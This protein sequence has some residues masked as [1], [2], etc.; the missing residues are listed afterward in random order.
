MRI[1]Q[2]TNKKF[3]NYGCF[4]QESMDNQNENK[5]IKD[6][7]KFEDE[8]KLRGYSKKTISAYL[9]Y[10]KIFFD[11]KLSSREFLLKLIK[12]GKGSETVRAAGFAVKL[13]EKIK[14]NLDFSEIPNMKKG[15]RLPIVLSKQEIQKMVL[16]ITNLVHRLIIKM[17]YSAG[18]RASELRNLCWEDI[19][20]YR[21]TIHIK[22]GK[23]NKDRI[24]MLSHRLKKDLREFTLNK[25]GPVFKTRRGNKYSLRSIQKIV[26]TAAKKAGIKSKITPHSLRHSFATHLLENGIDIRHIQKLLGHARLQTTQIYTQICGSDL[27]KIKSPLDFKLSRI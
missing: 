14:N 25:E 21:N 15:T 2:K 18:L 22:K 3:I 10:V 23:G 5:D 16:V 8:L 13:F 26:S 11:S 6:I 7:Q 19:N 1:Y 17:L 20:F 12:Q 24:V 4:L 27:S 9:R